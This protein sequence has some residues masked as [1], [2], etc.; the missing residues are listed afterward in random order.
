MPKV[1]ARNES[2]NKHIRHR[3]CQLSK[4]IGSGISSSAD[5]VVLVSDELSSSGKRHAEERITAPDKVVF[6]IEFYLFF[7]KNI[8]CG[9]LS[10]A[11]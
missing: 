9:Y 4:P 6:E 5:C 3:M 7:N 1:A 8:C 2:V 11:S 10:K